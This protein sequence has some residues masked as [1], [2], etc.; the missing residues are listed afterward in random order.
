[1]GSPEIPVIDTQHSTLKSGIFGYGD[2]SLD[3]GELNKTKE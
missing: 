2:Y 3:F 1:M